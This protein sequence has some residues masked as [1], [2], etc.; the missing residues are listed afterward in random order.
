VQQ[1]VIKL[2]DGFFHA[3]LDF[4]ELFNGMNPIVRASTTHV[5][6]ETDSWVAAFN[7]TIH[8]SKLAQNV[9]KA[10]HQP[11]RDREG[12]RQYLG[13]LY[14]HTL[15]YVKGQLPIDETGSRAVKMHNVPF[16]GKTWNVVDFQ[17]SRQ[18]VS[19]HH[20]IHLMYAEMLKNIEGW[21]PSAVE[22]ATNGIHKSY[23]S[24]L[25]TLNDDESDYVLGI[26]DEVVR[27]MSIFLSA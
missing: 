12:I 3:V 11:V 2:Q 13:A 22:K 8:L 5:E 14:H 26:I 27:G 6:Y 23:A 24:M 10:F 21:S 19:F 16:S 1:H 4:L 17:V 25:S 18:P 9:G 15:L 7:L 20:P